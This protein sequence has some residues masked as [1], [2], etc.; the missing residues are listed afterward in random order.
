MI[1]LFDDPREGIGNVAGWRLREVG[2]TV[3]PHLLDALN[4]ESSKVRWRAA[5]T[6]G[7]MER[8]HA[9]PAIPALREASKDSDEQVR[10]WS[11]WALEQIAPA[12]NAWSG[13][14]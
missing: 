3:V 8:E 7:G 2:P 1:K 14:S 5:W 10:K 11:G 9:L 12:P 6:L 13:H 4:A